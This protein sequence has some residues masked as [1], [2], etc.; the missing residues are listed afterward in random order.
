MADA[1]GAAAE[2]P[3]EGEDAPAADAPPADAAAD[4]P[5]ADAPAA[6]AADAPAADAPADAPAEPAADAA[7]ADAAAPAGDAAAEASAE[8]PA[9]SVTVPVEKVVEVTPVP[10]SPAV[11]IEAMEGQTRVVL[12]QDKG[13]RISVRDVGASL[14]PLKDLGAGKEDEDAAALL[15]RRKEFADFLGSILETGKEVIQGHKNP[16][17]VLGLSSWYTDLPDEDKASY[18]GMWDSLRQQVRQH[19]ADDAVLVLL[20]LVEDE[21]AR[22]EHRAVAFAA[23]QVQ[24]LKPDFAGLVL[25]SSVP[26]SGKLRCTCGFAADSPVLRVALSLEEGG[27]IVEGGDDGIAKWQSQCKEKCTEAFSASKDVIAGVCEK[28]AA[29]QVCVLAGLLQGIQAPAALLGQQEV[30]EALEKLQAALADAASAADK[31]AILRT[32]AALEALEGVVGS[33]L[34]VLFSEKWELG[35][36]TFNASWSVGHYLKRPQATK[37]V[38]QTDGPPPTPSEAGPAAETTEKEGPGKTEATTVDV[39]TSDP[40]GQ[41]TTETVQATA[42]ED[43]EKPEVP[44]PPPSGTTEQFR[45]N[46]PEPKTHIGPGFVVYIVAPNDDMPLSGADFS[47]IRSAAVQ[48]DAT[49]VLSARSASGLVIEEGKKVAESNRV[50]R[51][52]ADFAVRRFSPAGSSK[53]GSHQSAF[54]HLFEA[55]VLSGKEAVYRSVVEGLQNLGFPGDTAATAEA[56]LPVGIPKVTKQEF[57]NSLA[58]AFVHP[59]MVVV[60]PK[61]SKGAA[62]WPQ[63]R[64]VHFPGTDMTGEAAL[65]TKVA[66]AWKAAG[67]G[68]HGVI[69]VLAARGRCSMAPADYERQMR[70]ELKVAM[71][72]LPS[73]WPLLWAP[74]PAEVGLFPIGCKQRSNWAMQQ[75]YLAELPGW[76]RYLLIIRPNKL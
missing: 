43:P 53:A 45:S 18:E 15:Q 27:P 41:A 76:L 42:A 1:E 69:L 11:Y 60:C 10:R 52:L 21:E 67:R 33:S 32:A 75:A 13:D 46:E 44:M 66:E 56:L 72:G 51:P 31:A 34:Q 3:K 9:A 25:G 16:E 24:R 74:G 14:D 63:V 38:A 29:P 35:G 19:L 62:E 6:D 30:K 55:I 54:Q 70:Q 58:D 50:L 57:C 12:L 17:V 7:A 59:E 65:K 47:A 68:G 36:S 26:D 37:E 20:P 8:M 2:A 39:T 28:A 64:T 5:A 4:A 71:E 61:N 22:H 48:S 40:S 23:T 49:V 73:R